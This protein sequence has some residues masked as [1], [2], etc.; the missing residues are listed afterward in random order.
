[1]CAFKKIFISLTVIIVF[2]TNLSFA[3]D[4]KLNLTQQTYQHEHDPKRTY[5]SS[6][7]FALDTEISYAKATKWSSRANWEKTA[8]I[9]I[10]TAN[11]GHPTSQIHLGKLYVHGNGVP[12]DLVEAYKWFLLS[13]VSIAINHYIKII[14]KDMTKSE[15]AEAIKKAQNFKASYD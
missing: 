9:Y 8:A 5:L 2:F 4:K 13:E 7:A 11:R 15:I 3:I 1:M 6:D 12:V 10:K 14:S